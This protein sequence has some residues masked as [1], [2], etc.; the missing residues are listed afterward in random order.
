MQHIK[1]KHGL[2]RS[3]HRRIEKRDQIASA[4][5][6]T[7]LCVQFPGREEAELLQR[8]CSW[9][10]KGTKESH[11]SPVSKKDIKVEES[12]FSLFL[13]LSFLVNRKITGKVEILLKM[14][15]SLRQEF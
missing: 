5:L 2:W 1:N 4:W 15:F 9:G 14:S 10:L 13:L 7:F 12:S 3:G 11:S 8:G 6:E